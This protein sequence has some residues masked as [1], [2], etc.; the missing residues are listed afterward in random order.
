MTI[1]QIFGL[2]M[3]LV[4]VATI[5]S[6]NYLLALV[7]RNPTVTGKNIDEKLLKKT[8]TNLLED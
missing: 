6:I 7:K 2:V 4:G 1:L 8:S 5:S 3:A